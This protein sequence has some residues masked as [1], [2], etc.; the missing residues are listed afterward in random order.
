MTVVPIPVDAEPGDVARLLARLGIYG[1]DPTNVVEIADR[2]T[3]WAVTSTIPDGRHVR[4]I[5]GTP[6]TVTVSHPK[7]TPEWVKSG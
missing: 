2:D 4:R 5:A 1:V 3:C 6:V 7:Q